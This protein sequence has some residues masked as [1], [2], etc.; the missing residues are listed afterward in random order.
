MSSSCKIQ[1]CLVQNLCREG[2]GKRLLILHGSTFCCACFCCAFSFFLTFP[3]NW[4][5]IGLP[6]TSAFQ[7]EFWKIIFVLLLLTNTQVTSSLPACVDMHLAPFLASL[8]GTTK[9]NASWSFEEVLEVCWK[10]DKNEII[11]CSYV[12]PGTLVTHFSWIY[13]YY[14]F[15]ILADRSIYRYGG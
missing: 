12:L 7:G 15:L 3:I 6:P 4:T 2:G 10:R 13:F 5:Q 9:P 1:I 8:A 11:I 14:H